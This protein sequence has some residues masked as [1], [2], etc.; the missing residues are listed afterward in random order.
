[1]ID[2][3]GKSALREVTTVAA[4]WRR[5]RVTRRVLLALGWLLLGIPVALAVLGPLVA[6]STR[7]G[8]VPLQP[9]GGAHLL[10]TDVF[11][12]DVLGLA[13]AGGT[14]VVLLTAASLA[15]AY[16]VA[17]PL[18]L[19]VAAGARLAEDLVIRALDVVLALPSLL[20]LMALAATGRRG[21]GWLVLAVALVQVPYVVRLVRGAAAAP[22][23]LTALETMTLVGEPWWRVHLLETGRRVL[24]PVLVNA[25][26]RVVTVVGLLSSANFLGVGLA[27]AAV[28]WAVLV[29]QNMTALFLAPAVVLVPA[30]LLVALCAG[31]NL[32]VDELLERRVRA[33]TG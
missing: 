8:D 6:P 14:S 7:P 27:P 31:T 24:P 29:D 30:G 19:V 20:V 33:V 15:L 16:A 23:C 9:P 10:G 22:A 25:A 1:M 21:V 2:L 4:P 17:V 18:G 11:G 28:D 13:L 3:A 12:R 26:T 32:L 5:G